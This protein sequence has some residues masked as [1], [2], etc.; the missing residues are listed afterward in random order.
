VK[1]RDDASDYRRGAAVEESLASSRSATKY[2]AV[3]PW[4][5]RVI[6]GNA[7]KY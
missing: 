4:R 3:R 7:Q 2:V 5:E 1:L 6:V